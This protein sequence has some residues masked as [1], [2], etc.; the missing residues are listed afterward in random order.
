M[1]KIEH[2]DTWQWVAWDDLRQMKPK[3]KDQALA[4][5]AMACAIGASNFIEYLAWLNILLKSEPE[6]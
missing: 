2:P 4:R 6:E 1:T 5:F 3:T